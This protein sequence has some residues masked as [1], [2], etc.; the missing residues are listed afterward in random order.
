MNGLRQGEDDQEFTAALL[1]LSDRI[2]EECRGYN[3]T[4]FRRM[5]M[6]HGG[7]KTV[8]QLLAGPPDT[9]GMGR[10]WEHGRLDL[11]FEAFVLAD[12]RWHSLFDATELQKMRSNLEQFGYDVE[13]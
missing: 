2:A 3:P 7:L 6:E 4:T 1:N 13:R 5:V 9:Y 8:R 12:K 11:S 10:L